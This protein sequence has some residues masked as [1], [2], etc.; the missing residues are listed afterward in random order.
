MVLLCL[1]VWQG[2]AR[3]A[4]EIQERATAPFALDRGSLTVPLQIDGNP[5]TFVLD[6]GAE[7]SMV[8]PGAVR[9]LDLTLDQWVGTTMHGVGGVVEHPNADPR[10]LTLGGL[11]LRRQT[12]THD[13]SLTVGDLPRM[14]SG[15][16]VDGL[17]GRDFLSLFDLL[18]DMPGRRLVLYAVH[19]CSGRFLPW[20]FP[21]DAVQATTPMTHALVLPFTLDDRQLTALLDSGAST[22]M[23]TLS[24]MIRLGL[25][26][27]MLAHDQAAA[28]HGVGRQAPEMHQHRF[29]RLQVGGEAMRQPLLWVAPVRVVPFVDGLLGADWLDAQRLVW[30]SFATS[31]VFF[32]PR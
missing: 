27:A 9:R 2:V 4:C 29:D 31:Q 1:M 7:R 32:V 14:R 24:G 21:Y 11:A 6:T 12:V 22:S 23:I 13:T 26:P 5:A 20:S 25:S 28:L 8:T 17:L 18:L 3:A 19:D 16:P 30:I 10:S 15:A